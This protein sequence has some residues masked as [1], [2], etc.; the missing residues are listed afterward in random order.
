MP[1]SWV[2]VVFAPSTGARGN[3]DRLHVVGFPEQD[4]LER[5]FGICGPRV[6]PSG[7]IRAVALGVGTVY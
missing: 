7:E 5:W 1:D 2:A 4:D 3:E 6:A